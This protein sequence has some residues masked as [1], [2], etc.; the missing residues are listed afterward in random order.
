MKK[1]F[2]II[3]ISVALGIA[4]SPATSLAFFGGGEPPWE[5]PIIP[6]GKTVKTEDAAIF[7][8]YDQ[9]YEQ[10]LAWYKEALKTYPDEAYRD[11]K[12]QTY[13]EDQ[14][15]AKWHSIGI[16]KGTGDKTTVKITRDNYTWV[17]STLLIR[18]AGVFLV[19]C[20][21]WILL[22]INSAIMRKFFPEK[23]K[24]TAK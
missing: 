4:F 1:L 14:G 23:K 2:Y 15:G 8:E 5:A 24:V 17:F 19:L 20:I 6:G 22:N 3:C 18:F 10:V 13:I 16:Y 9:K 21:L 12:D 11:W 7:V